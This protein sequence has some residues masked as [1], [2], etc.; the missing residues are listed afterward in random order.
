MSSLKLCA[1]TICARDEGQYYND[2]CDTTHDPT[3]RIPAAGSKKSHQSIE[4]AVCR[5]KFTP[6]TLSAKKVK[7]YY[8]REV[9]VAGSRHSRSLA[10]VVVPLDNL[11]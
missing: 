11:L 6:V 8:V 5:A 1:K 7:E 10:H 9:A 2:E 4:W 3:A